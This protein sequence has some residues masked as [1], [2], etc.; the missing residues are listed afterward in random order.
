VPWGR[1]SAGTKGAQGWGPQ[2]TAGPGGRC[3]FAHFLGCPCA[4]DCRC[5]A[6][7][8]SRA[9]PSLDDEGEEPDHRNARSLNR[10]ALGRRVEPARAFA[11]SQQVHPQG[12]V[13]GL[14][15]NW[16]SQGG[17]CSTSE[18]FARSHAA[19]R[20]ETG[21]RKSCR[22]HPVGRPSGPFFG[23]LSRCGTGASRSPTNV[24][25]GESAPR[26][27]QGLSLQQNSPRME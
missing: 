17:L 10:S 2:K 4:D 27:L 6:V 25:F 9:S 16:R 18:S 21:S 22:G 8:P 3:W 5:Y 26:S 12:F 19:G 20:A 1:K 11:A 13:Q 23:L 15:A 24:T 14:W 7:A